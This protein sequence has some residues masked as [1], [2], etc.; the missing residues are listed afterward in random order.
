[1]NAP[2]QAKDTTKTLGTAA[3]EKYRPKMNALSNEERQILLGCL[4]KELAAHSVS[5]WM[6]ELRGP[7]ISRP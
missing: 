6:D 4:K 3:V 5:E 1:M 2:K 7:V